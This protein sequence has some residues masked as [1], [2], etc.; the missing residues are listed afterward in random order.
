MKLIVY[1]EFIIRVD[2]VCFLHKK[3]ISY[4]FK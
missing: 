3:K 2:L 4:C 1:W